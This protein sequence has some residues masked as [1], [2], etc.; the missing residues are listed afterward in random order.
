MQSDPSATFAFGD[1][2]T[3]KNIAPN[4]IINFFNN[5]RLGGKIILTP[6]N[7]ENM[8]V[9][10]NKKMISS[11]SAVDTKALLEY[12][13]GNT[14][15]GQS[16]SH[17]ACSKATDRYFVC[18]AD[19]YL[20]ITIIQNHTL[21]DLIV[22]NDNKG[23]ADSLWPETAAIGKDIF[24]N[25]LAFNPPQAGN[26]L[27]NNQSLKFGDIVLKKSSDYV[28]FSSYNVTSGGYR[29]SVLFDNFQAGLSL[30]STYI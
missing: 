4:Y 19:G 8:T 15:D 18:K 27:N 1:E 12:Y 3:V 30:T 2:A 11:K 17:I 14:I 21:Y 20:D 6:K 24:Q 9:I 13:R 28:Y 29:A 25:V 5:S 22:S 7:D 10:L 16:D 26:R 23:S